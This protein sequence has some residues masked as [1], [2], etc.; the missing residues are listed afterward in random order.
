MREMPL[1]CKSKAA[2]I[3]NGPAA[4]A[5]CGP[6]GGSK[7]RR[8]TEAALRAHLD[9]RA[10]SAQ[11]CQRQLL[12]LRQAGEEIRTPNAD[13]ASQGT[14]PIGKDRRGRSLT[15]PGLT[16]KCR[17]KVELHSA[18]FKEHNRKRRRSQVLEREPRGG[19]LGSQQLRCLA[20]LP[21]AWMHSIAS[22]P[23]AVFANACSVWHAGSAG[24]GRPTTHCHW[25][26]GIQAA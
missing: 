11:P 6:R 25:L 16:L 18:A 1:R 9:M 20:P 19:P 5:N 15:S 10:R 13:E 12:G 8:H 21:Q 2:W 22:C 3:S 14:A 24:L 23:F 4:R 26:E 7:S 17:V